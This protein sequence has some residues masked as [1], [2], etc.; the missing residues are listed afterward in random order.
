M[1]EKL[2]LVDGNSLV[3]RAFHALPPLTNSEGQPTNAIYGLAQMLLLLLEEQ[4]PAAVLVAF[5]SEGPTFRHAQYERYKEDRKETPQE[6]ISQF[7]L[8]RELVDGL[9]LRRAEL[10]GFEAD[11]IIGT[12]ARRATQEGFQVTIVTG[13]RDLLQLVD[14]SVTVMTTLRGIKETR[15]YDEQGVREE[16]GL[17]PE[18]IVDLKAL[19]GDTSDSIPGVPGIGPKTAQKLL[20]EYGSVE[21]LLANLDQVKSVRVAQALREHADQVMVSKQLAQIELQMPLELEAG[22]CRWEGFRLPEL[23]ALLARLE[24]SRLLDRLPRERADAPGESVSCAQ[25]CALAREQGSV[26]I[27]VTELGPSRLGV[28]LMAP[29]A[30]AGPSSPAWEVLCGQQSAECVGGGLFALDEPAPSADD[31]ELRALLQDPA[32]AKWGADLKAAATALAEV[33][34]E[35]SGMA[36]DASVASYLLAPQR[37]SHALEALAFQY[38]HREAPGLD[39]H[40]SEEQRAAQALTTVTLLPGLR[41]ELL[42]ALEREGL[43]ELFEQM[44]MPLIHILR[45]MEATGIAVDRERL[46]DLGRELDLLLADLSR[47]IFAIAGREFNI[48]SPQQLATVLFDELKLPRGRKTKTGWSTG[49]EVLEELATECEI[50]RL[51]IE[52]REYAKLRSTYVEGLV[53]QIEPRTGRIHTTFEQTVAATGRLSSRGPNLQ[54]IPIRTEWGRQIRACFVAVGQEMTLLAADY[55]Q[56][57]LRILAHMSS[58]PVL[59][60][61]FAAGHDVHASTAAALFAVPLADVDKQMRRIAK[62]VNYA[63]VYG[64]G[65]AALS[66]Q[67]G[68]S[69]DEAG[70]FITAYHERF[71]G[72]KQF[73]DGI[74]AQA[75]VDGMV[76]TLFGRKRPLPDL[77]SSNPGVRAYSERAAANAPLQGSAADIMKIAMVRL[78]ETLPRLCPEARMLL[79]VHDELVFEL[80]H[81]A[82][83]EVGQH[84]KEI[85]EGAAKLRIPLVADVEH[86]PNW[87]DMEPLQGL[88]V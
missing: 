63:V 87:R 13:D 71:A 14:D 24:F 82:V 34:V 84:V 17:A 69:R 19:S 44:E 53:S 22:Q 51:I 3:H 85:M 41:G 12:M 49:A 58:D 79:Q 50:A 6:L 72:V 52:H 16:Y 4:Q 61:A 86:G 31:A 28:A 8:A 27:V 42:T 36:F 70:S 67:L 77:G 55:S 11:D 47:R 40:P 35:L 23:R 7:G 15:S 10:T 25:A 80:P 2:L 1:P 30:S 54:N 62:T 37:K 39:K 59:L 48:G 21:E 38:L 33:G 9:G 57:E 88:T 60:E 65:A 75:K 29:T 45:D 68:I 46:V 73:M 64:M 74:V 56:I 78:G 26:C 43:L 66:Q 18:Q 20:G 83:G 5:D 81:T 32:V 76:T